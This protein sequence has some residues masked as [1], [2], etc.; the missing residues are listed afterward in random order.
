MV[1]FLGL[2]LLAIKLVIGWFSGD[3]AWKEAVLDVVW[4]VMILQITLTV[5]V[6]I[7]RTIGTVIGTV[8]AGMVG[9]KIGAYVQ[10][11]IESMKHDAQWAGG[12]LQSVIN[13]LSGKVSGGV[14]LAVAA[15][16]LLLLGTLRY[17]VNKAFL[18]GGPY[19][20]LYG[21]TWTIFAGTDLFGFNWAYWAG[22]VLYVLGLYLQRAKA[23]VSSGPSLM[24]R[25]RM[26]R[27]RGR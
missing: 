21:A 3:V 23:S 20:F 27:R 1:E 15:F 12:P 26:Q 7:I 14:V 6:L 9:G 10:K 4:W 22:L 8:F 17:L 5:L 11:H 19:L 25:R 2:L 18:I 16:G 13:K 24:E